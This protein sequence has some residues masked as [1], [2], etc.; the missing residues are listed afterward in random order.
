MISCAGD[1][2]SSSR[3]VRQ[4]LMPAFYP[5]TAG[6]VTNYQQRPPNFFDQ[7]LRSNISTVSSDGKLFDETLPSARQQQQYPCG[8]GPATSPQRTTVGIVGGSE[9]VPN[10]WPF[11]VSCWFPSLPICNSVSIDFNAI[12]CLTGGTE[13][14]WTSVLRR[15]FD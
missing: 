12:S 11:I 4:L 14:K 7:W 13:E 1:V 10:S 6:L 8:R 2:A 9:A 15:I 5:Y 3:T